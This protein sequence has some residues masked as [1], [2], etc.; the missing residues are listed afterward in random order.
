[1][2]RAILKNISTYRETLKN[3]IMYSETV[4]Q[5]G[6]F[7]KH[8]FKLPFS[9]GAIYLDFLPVGVQGLATVF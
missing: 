4:L 8:L 1:V 5:H 3:N 7:D 9:W 6:N 2:C